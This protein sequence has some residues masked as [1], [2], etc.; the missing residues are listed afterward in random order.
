[1]NEESAAGAAKTLHGRA[2]VACIDHLLVV[3]A[4]EQ[5]GLS[6]M[7]L[8]SCGDRPGAPSARYWELDGDIIIVALKQYSRIPAWSSQDDPG[9]SKRYSIVA[10]SVGEAATCQLI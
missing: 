1:M 7:T 4:G 8:S 9:A 10:F 2:T 3:A 6:R 5:P